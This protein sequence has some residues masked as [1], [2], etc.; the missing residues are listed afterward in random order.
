MSRLVREISLMEVLDHPNVVRLY[1]TFETTDSLFIVMEYV[2][3]CNLDEYL[4]QKGGKISEIEARGIF[5]QMAAA[6]DYCH[7][8]WVVHRDL[9]VGHDY[10]KIK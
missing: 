7:S 6:M 10:K 3:G 1:E 2:E 4:Q 8:R 5:R 9:K